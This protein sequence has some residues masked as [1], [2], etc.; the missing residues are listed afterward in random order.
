MKTRVAVS[1]GELF[2]GLLRSRFAIF[3]VVWLVVVG[4]A[5][6]AEPPAAPD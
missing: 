2:R 4:L 3:G 6:A 5:A 1:G